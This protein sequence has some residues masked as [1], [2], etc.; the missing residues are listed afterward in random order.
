[1][2]VK[3]SAVLLLVPTLPDRDQHFSATPPDAPSTQHNG[4]PGSQA[5]LDD[6]ESFPNLQIALILFLPSQLG[7]LLLE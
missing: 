4:L 2:T 7:K 5:S 3:F 6:H 1:M